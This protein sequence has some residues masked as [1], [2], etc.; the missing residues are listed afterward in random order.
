[1]EEEN[2]KP[3]PNGA[4]NSTSDP[5]EQLMWNFYVEKLSKGIEN[6]YQSAIEAGYED[7]T[8]RQITVRSWFLERK[9]KL[10]RKDMLS[11][12][13]RNLNKALDYTIENDEGKIMP[14]IAK[15]V[16]DVSKTI[17]STLGK[18]D[19]YSNRVENTGA[20]GEPLNINVINF[21]TN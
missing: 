4:N 6:A 14:E 15:I 12:A 17:V 16:I 7:S 11:K 13:E 3:N 18:D 8:A 19:G 1:M 20:N 5:R 9:S 10:R 21:K 2:K